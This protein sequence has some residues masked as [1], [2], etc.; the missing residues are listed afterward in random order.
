MAGTKVQPVKHDSQLDAYLGEWVAVKSGR[1]IAHSKDSREVVRELRKLPD[2][3][4]GAVL[5]RV[6]SSAEPLAVG[7]G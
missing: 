5:Q 2:K 1:V 7:L 4:R 6:A 3:G